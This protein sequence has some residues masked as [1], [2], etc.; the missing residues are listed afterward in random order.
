MPVGELVEILVTAIG[1]RGGEPGAVRQLEGQD[2]RGMAS[3]QL[4][5]LGHRPNLPIWVR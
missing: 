1:D 2:R 5:Q 3:A 4:L